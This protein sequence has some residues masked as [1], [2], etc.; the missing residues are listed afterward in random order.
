MDRP[1]LELQELTA[2]LHQGEPL[3]AVH[4]AGESFLT[5]RDHPP[6][7]AGISIYDLHS[8]EVIGFNRADSPPA[9]ADTGREIALLERF[10]R[11]LEELDDQRVLHWNANRPEYGFAALATR[12]RFL[13][14]HAPPAPRPR[15]LYDVDALIAARHGPNYAPHGRLETIARINGLDVRS[16]RQST[17]EARLFERSDWQ[18]LG[19]SSAGKARV[20]GELLRLLVAGTLRT[21][22]TGSRS[23]RFAAAPIDAVALVLDIGQRFLLVQ[24]R[25]GRHPHGRP[26]LA[27]KDEWDDQY[28][29]GALL[30]LFFDDVRDEE[31]VPSHAGGGSRIDFLLPD[32]GLAVELKH[33]RG[34]MRAGELGEQVM[35]DRQR[36]RAHPSVTGLVVLVFDHQGLLHNPRGL[37]KDLQTRY[38]DADLTVTVRI[39]D[40]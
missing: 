12:Y 23:T 5:A 8:L 16:F 25:L 2:A 1:D 10:Y 21:S 35:I 32:T 31:P 28:L 13:T 6:A 17:A 34:S 26:P 30:S 27:F 24:R 4:Y 19:R 29:F 33:T 7:V 39:Y 15:R 14:G 36:Y 38:S 18:A 20:I 3:I 40:R 22:S 37:E 9:V 11:H